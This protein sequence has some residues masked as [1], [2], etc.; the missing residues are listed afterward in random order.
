MSEPTAPDP[1]EVH[2]LLANLPRKRVPFEDLT[3]E[4]YD[5]L[6]DSLELHR[7]R[8]RELE[9][10]RDALQEA[11][12]DD[13]KGAMILAQWEAIAAADADRDRL[14]ALLEQVDAAA[15]SLLADLLRILPAGSG[16][17]V[18]ATQISELLASEDER[19]AGGAEVSR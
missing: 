10:E 4:K 9:V 18:K 16:L 1:A 15:G 13:D 3:P 6:Y 2:R 5:R 12:E 19:A 11:L 7:A 17:Y 14:T 8:V